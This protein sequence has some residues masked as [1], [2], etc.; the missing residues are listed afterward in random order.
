MKLPSWELVNVDGQSLIAMPSFTQENL[1]TKIE[2]TLKYYEHGKYKKY[3]R[4]G[5]YK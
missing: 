1:V 2:E 5:T 3:N 4:V